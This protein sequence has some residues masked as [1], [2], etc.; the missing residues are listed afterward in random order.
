[1]GRRYEIL[2]TI[3]L[4]HDFYTKGISEDFSM[5]PTSETLQ[6]LKRYRMMLK[7]EPG[8]ITVLFETLDDNTVTPVIAIDSSLTFNF[9]LK[10]QRT[11]FV[12]ITDYSV[13]PALATPNHVYKFSN[14]GVALLQQTAVLDES[15]AR[16]SYFGIIGIT[17][18]DNSTTV[19]D[20]Y[21]QFNKKSAAWNYY[22]VL[23]NGAGAN[24][25]TIT[26]GATVYN[27]TVPNDATCTAL[28]ANLS[29]TAAVLLISTNTYSYNEEPKAGLKL[30]KNS[31]EVFTNL[32]NPSISNPKPEVILFAD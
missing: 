25:Y 26:D 16:Q 31:T 32:P 10:I 4:K 11:Q 7:K 18:T 1:M 30:K 13:L 20:Y 28:K 22:V 12:N 15:L 21:V 19:R 23:K 27:S 8:K 3:T 9:L 2:F 14:G 29:N 5:E 17:K 6:L 24:T